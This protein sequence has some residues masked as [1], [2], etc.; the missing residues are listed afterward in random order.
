MYEEEL[1]E[2][3]QENNKSILI[4]GKFGTGK[5]TLLRKVLEK[6]QF[7]TSKILEVKMYD[8]FIEE[9]YIDFLFS[10]L[11]GEEYRKANV[12]K[13]IHLKHGPS[14]YIAITDVV[15]LLLLQ[16]VK[17]IT[18]N[19]TE[20]N[21]VIIVLIGINLFILNFCKERIKVKAEKISY[22]KKKL[23]KYDYLVIDDLDRVYTNTTEVLKMVHFLYENNA[24]YQ[25]ILVSDRKRFES[26]GI[27]VLEKY[28]DISF[29]MPAQ[30]IAEEGMKKLNKSLEEIRYQDEVTP[31][32]NLLKKL[33]IRTINKVT[34]HYEYDLKFSTQRIKKLF[35]SDYL[36]MLIMNYKYN[37][38]DFIVDE[39]CRIQARDNVFPFNQNTPEKWKE[40]LEKIKNMPLEKEETLYII[41]CFAYAIERP[42]YGDKINFNTMNSTKRISDNRLWDTP[43]IYRINGQLSQSYSHDDVVNNFEEWVKNN[44]DSVTKPMYLKYK[45]TKG[46]EAK[47]FMYKFINSE[48][49]TIA[50]KTKLYNFVSDD[51]FGDLPMIEKE[52][53][54]L[55]LTY[56]INN[57]HYDSSMIKNRYS[58]NIGN[59]KKLWGQISYVSK[60]ELISFEVTV[61]EKIFS[62]KLKNDIEE[63]NNLFYTMSLLDEPWY[64]IEIFSEEII[65]GKVNKDALISVKE[66]IEKRKYELQNYEGR[67]HNSKKVFNDY[68]R[69][70]EL[71]DNG[72]STTKTEKS[73]E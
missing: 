61:E 16:C 34:K 14:A 9:N 71:L 68:D 28:Y 59:F 27:D 50:D 20:P 32:L 7:K 72:I 18:T 8:E 25:I 31:V 43:E 36:F 30:L 73:V 12:L 26:D 64:N 65:D 55:Y 49:L 40:K 46:Y 60:I 58:N 6:E 42:V 21:T 24:E 15:L 51:I 19:D 53:P 70:I 63:L 10:K 38:A 11:K 37:D 45:H 54:N 69:Q 3:L 41:R 57:S 13:K 23:K 1:C 29:E 22:I 56:L 33:D 5:T 44:R 35:R 39:L 48:A 52:F 62:D 66:Q 2:L 17:L 47:D 4:S 67:I